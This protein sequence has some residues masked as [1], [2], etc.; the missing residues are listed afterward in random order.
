MLPQG[1]T[2]ITSVNADGQNFIATLVSALKLESKYWPTRLL[3]P[4]RLVVLPSWRTSL[5]PG[6]EP[7]RGWYRVPSC[8]P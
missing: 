7:D 3:G 2:Q 1:Y 8:L 4:W 6:H 5:A